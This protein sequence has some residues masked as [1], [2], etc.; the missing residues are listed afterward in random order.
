M[1]IYVEI[2]DVQIVL[3]VHVSQ[4]TNMLATKKT[5]TASAG[6]AMN[7]N[8]ASRDPLK[9]EETL[10]RIQSQ[11]GVHGV[12]VITSDG[13]VLRSNLDNVV[14]IQYATLCSQ[15]CGLAAGV[16]R[17]L[18]TENELKILR[19]RTKKNELMISPGK[20]LCLIVPVLHIAAKNFII[21]VVQNPED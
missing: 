18:D 11:K 1:Q 2:D 12:V 17:D 6:S 5:S 10:A 21:I 8:E 20:L 7:L 3:F 19:I 14:T 15:L 9:V 13:A 16:V 4:S